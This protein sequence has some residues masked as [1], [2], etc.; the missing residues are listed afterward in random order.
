MSTDEFNENI[1]EILKID[2]ARNFE[3]YVEIFGEERAQ[4]YID[5]IR[6]VVRDVDRMFVY[7]NRYTSL[8]PSKPADLSKQFQD[9]FSEKRDLSQ[10][11]GVNFVSK[12][13]Y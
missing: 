5:A 13:K 1:A 11:V 6:H 4:G 2:S 8:A 10:E 3:K 7:R 12:Y 9:Y